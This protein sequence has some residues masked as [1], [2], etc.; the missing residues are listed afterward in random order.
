MNIKA[1]FVL[2]YWRFVL[3]RCISVRYVCCIMRKLLLNNYIENRAELLTYIKSLWY[4]YLQSEFPSF[5]YFRV[6]NDHS[7]KPLFYKNSG[8]L[9]PCWNKTKQRFILCWIFFSSNIH[10]IF[11]VVIEIQ[12]YTYGKQLIELLNLLRDLLQTCLFSDT[13]S[14]T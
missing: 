11:Q 4:T 2:I 8:P 5:C 6:K 10:N 1:V 9:G 13:L 12:F 14:R 7:F 3:Q